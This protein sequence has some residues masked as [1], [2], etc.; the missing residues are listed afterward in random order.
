MYLLRLDDACETI[1]YER[2]TTLEQLLDHYGIKP[3]VGVIPH[4]DDPE[5]QQYP[6]DANFWNK[7]IDW[8]SKGWTIAMHG[9]N[10][11]YD[12]HEAG[13]NPMW[14]RSE[15][16]GLPLNEQCEKVRLGVKIFRQNGVAPRYFFAPSHTFDNNTLEALRCESNIRVVSDTFALNPYREGDFVFV[17]RTAG[18]CRHLPIKGTFTFSLHPA[19]MNRAAFLELEQF[20]K[21]YRSFFASFDDIDYASVGQMSNVD[22]LVSKGFWLLKKV[23]K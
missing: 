8:Q 5:L 21:K 16:A 7:V 17:P 4:N 15:F 2:W 3:L 20:L 12:S 19:T 13:I 11:V 10:H 6:I 14:N 1:D 18:R 22:K 9:Y 23:R